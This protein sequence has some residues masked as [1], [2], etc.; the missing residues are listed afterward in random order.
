M[1][2]IMVRATSSGW[3]TNTDAVPPASPEMNSLVVS[4]RLL[5]LTSNDQF[6]VEKIHYFVSKTV[7]CRNHPVINGCPFER[8]INLRT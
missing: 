6:I 5:I 7:N 2:F 4:F 1:M 3:H 8:Y